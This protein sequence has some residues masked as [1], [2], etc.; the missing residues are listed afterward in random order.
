MGFIKDLLG[1]KSREEKE[2]EVLE[3][4]LRLIEDLKRGDIS[5]PKYKREVKKI[6]Q[7]MTD[8]GMGDS[9]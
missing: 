7:R 9:K 5:I 8:L 1:I 6:G 2:M 3:D 4:W